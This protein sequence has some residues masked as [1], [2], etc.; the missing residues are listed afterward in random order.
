MSYEITNDD[1]NIFLIEKIVFLASRSSCEIAIDL[2][3]SSGE[4][5]EKMSI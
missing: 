3:T 5:G 1:K 4:N 2:P